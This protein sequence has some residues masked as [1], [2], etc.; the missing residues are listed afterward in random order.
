MSLDW[1]N[2]DG[3]LVNPPD[4]KVHGAHMRPIWGRQ[5]PG[6]PRVGPMKFVIWAVLGMVLTC[7]AWQLN[8][9]STTYFQLILN[10]NASILTQKTSH[11]VYVYLKFHMIHNHLPVFHNT[12]CLNHIIL[13]LC[14]LQLHKIYSDSVTEIYRSPI[15][16]TMDM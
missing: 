6:G 7:L 1:R 12:R 9:T 4:S 16:A 10:T 11:D 3:C 5:D 2:N 8:G 13:L 15:H 14:T